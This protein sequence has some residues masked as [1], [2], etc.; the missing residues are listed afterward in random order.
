[1]DTLLIT[2]IVNVILLSLAALCTLI[3]LVPIICTRRFHTTTN[4]LTCNVCLTSILCCLYWIVFN[5]ILGFYPLLLMPSTFSYIFSS[6]F[7]SVTVCLLVYSLATVTINR[8]LTILYPNKRFFK[9]QAWPY[10]SSSVQWVV[11]II[12]PIPFFIP[13]IQ[14][15]IS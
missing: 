1:M 9:R 2:I 10:L 7:Q 3:Y 6:Y 15:N 14:V 5:V 4:I 13:Y 12:L 11:S 8:F